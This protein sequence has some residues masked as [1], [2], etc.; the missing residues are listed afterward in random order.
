MEI[1]TKINEIMI[2]I[3]ILKNKIKCTLKIKKIIITK[4]LIIYKF[5]KFSTLIT[6]LKNVF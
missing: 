3:I 1:L 2:I 4:I 6:K 5:Q